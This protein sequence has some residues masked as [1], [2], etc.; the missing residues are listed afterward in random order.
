MKFINEVCDNSRK[1][2]YQNWIELSTQ[3]I[4]RLPPNEL[5]VYAKLRSLTKMTT[6]DEGLAEIAATTAGGMKISVFKRAFAE[7]VRK[8]C[9]IWQSNGNGGREIEIMEPEFWLK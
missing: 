7:L 2:Y 9:L 6:T 3:A 8:G 5:A 1:T 4:N